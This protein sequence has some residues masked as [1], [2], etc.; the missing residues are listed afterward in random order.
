MFNSSPYF[1]GTNYQ[2]YETQSSVPTPWIYGHPQPP[3]A[4]TPY[5]SQPLP[6]S[7]P[8]QNYCDKRYESHPNQS[9]NPQPQ[10]SVPLESYYDVECDAYRS[11][12]EYYNYNYSACQYI[13]VVPKNDYCNA[14]YNSSKVAIEYNKINLPSHCSNESTSS[15]DIVNGRY[16]PTSLS[17]KKGDARLPSPESFIKECQSGRKSNERLTREEMI[18]NTLLSNK[19]HSSEQKDVR[20][21]KKRASS[22]S[23][24][25][26]GFINLKKISFKKK[27]QKSNFGKEFKNRHETNEEFLRRWR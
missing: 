18:K 5:Y 23:E 11:N 16:K 3:S 19:S 27:S 9:V 1:P 26:N 24:E 10:A 6:S 17:D 22:I 12:S 13:D 14:L 4:V 25:R 8:G 21:M 2:Y 20:E 15:S 7:Y